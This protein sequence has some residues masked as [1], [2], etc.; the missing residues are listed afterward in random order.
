[1]SFTESILEIVF[2]VQV[3]VYKLIWQKCF[4]GMQPATTIIAFP[5]EKIV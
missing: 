2:Y 1:M 5:L 3:F 4:Y